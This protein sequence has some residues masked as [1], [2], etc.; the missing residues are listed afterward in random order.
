MTGHRMG[1]RT[2][3]EQARS[4]VGR[5]SRCGK[6]SYPSRKLARQAARNYHGEGRLAPYQCPHNDQA[7]HNGHLPAAVRAGD[8]DRD[9]YEANARPR[10]VYA[11]A[12]AVGQPLTVTLIDPRDGARIVDALLTAADHGSGAQ[13]RHYRRIAE[14]LG[15]AL[16]RTPVPPW[17]ADHGG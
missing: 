7:W 12:A 10:A 3:Q 13:G 16:D 4:S 17:E 2:Q 11:H 8:V 15:D 5:C 1:Q 6:R 9:E 14:R